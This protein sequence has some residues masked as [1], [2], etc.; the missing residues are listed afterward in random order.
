VLNPG[1]GA[2]P[3]LVITSRHGARGDPQ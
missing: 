3:S 1:L 2:K